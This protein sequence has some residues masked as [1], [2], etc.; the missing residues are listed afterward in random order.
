G[1]TCGALVDPVAV[2]R[3]GS[4]GELGDPERGRRVVMALDHVADPLYLLLELG[5]V[6][7]VWMER[8]GVE[9]GLDPS[10]RVE[11][12]QEVPRGDIPIPRHPGQADLGTRVDALDGGRGDLQ[13]PR[14]L[15]GRGVW[16]E[17]LLDVR[18]VPDLPRGDRQWSGRRAELLVVLGRPIVTA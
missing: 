16:G 5:H 14:V 15:A 9:E 1:L 7:G 3:R 8:R 12:L 13:E 18:L 2:R 4:P 6:L 10:Y 11:L 17:E